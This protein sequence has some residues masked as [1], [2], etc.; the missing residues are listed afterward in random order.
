[1]RISNLLRAGIAPIFAIQ[2]LYNLGVIYNYVLML[3][4]AHKESR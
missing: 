3:W 2:D 4:K 1:M